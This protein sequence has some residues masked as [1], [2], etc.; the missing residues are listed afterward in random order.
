MWVG[1]E[2]LRLNLTQQEVLGLQLL[3]NREDIQLLAVFLL[4]VFYLLIHVIF[5]HLP[6]IVLFF[7]RQEHYVDAV[8][9]LQF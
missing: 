2:S 8:N 4:F 5:S 7:H 3:H 6:H 9:V 1:F